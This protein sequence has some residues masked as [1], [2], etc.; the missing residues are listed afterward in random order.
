MEEVRR[1]HVDF[2]GT[3]LPCFLAS[4]RPIA[5]ACF[6]LVTFLPLPVFNVPFFFFSIVFLTSFCAPLLYAGIENPPLLHLFTQFL[7]HARLDFKE[8]T[9]RDLK[10][11]APP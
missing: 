8:L 1:C 3:F 2:F 4:D 7:K 11:N 9:V 10:S 5:M 6:R